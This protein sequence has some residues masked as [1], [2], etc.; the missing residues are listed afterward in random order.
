MSFKL[1]TYKPNIKLNGALTLIYT[2][3]AKERASYNKFNVLIQLPASIDLAKCE[4]IE[5]VQENKQIT[6][7]LLRTHYDST[8]DL[9]LAITHK[10]IVKTVFLNHINDNHNTVD[11]TKYNNAA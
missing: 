1:I 11:L 2:N 8:F 9:C 4:I 5:S 7:L 10:G 6:G 3:H